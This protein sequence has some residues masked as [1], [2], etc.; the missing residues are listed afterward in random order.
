MLK[1]D[2]KI[3][4]FLLCYQEEENLRLLLPKI[5][6]VLESNNYNYEIIVIDTA[7]PKDNTRNVCEKFNV[8]YFNR[9]P[10]DLYGDAFRTAIQKMNGTFSIF[11]D[12]DGS[13]SPDFITTMIDKLSSDPTID[14]LIASRYMSGGKTD[15]TFLLVVMSRVLNIL[16]A[17]LL[18]FN[19]KDVSNSFRLYRNSALQ[20]VTLKCKNFDILEELLFRLNN[21]KFKIVEIPFTF[22]KRIY[23][24][25]KRNLFF[26]TLSYFSTLCK[27]FFLKIFIRN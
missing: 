9:E 10:S 15:N 23:G 1:E 13:H 7:K 25:S 24:E 16:Y 26:F 12:A 27:L 17:K 4:I 2:I 6:S 3:N 20:E 18:G 14:V 22:E 11:M 19:C 5:H 21:K 8:R